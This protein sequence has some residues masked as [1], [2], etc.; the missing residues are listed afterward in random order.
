MDNTR[1]CSISQICE[2][3]NAPLKI[4][5]ASASLEISS[6]DHQKPDIISFE[7]TT[8]IGYQ[9]TI[10]IENIDQNEDD[11]AQDNLDN[12]EEMR[13]NLEDLEVTKEK[14]YLE[15][16]F[17][18]LHCVGL[19]SCK[20]FWK[21]FRW[22]IYAIHKVLSCTLNTLAVLGSLEMIKISSLYF[23]KKGDMYRFVTIGRQITACA[24]GL[25]SVAAA[26]TE[27]LFGCVILGNGWSLLECVVYQ[28]S[29][30][31]LSI[32]VWT[33]NTTEFWVK[34][35][36]QEEMYRNSTNITPTSIFIGVTST[37][38]VYLGSLSDFVVNDIMFLSGLTM[39]ELTKEFKLTLENGIATLDDVLIK[40]E[41]LQTVSTCIV[42]ALGGLLKIAHASML[43]ACASILMAL[44]QGNEYFAADILLGLQILKV[45]VTYYFAIQAAA[46]NKD[47]R[48]WVR[49]EI[50][51]NTATDYD[52][53]LKGL[54]L[55]DESLESPLGLGSETFFIDEVFVLKFVTMVGTFTLFLMDAKRKS[56][57]AEEAYGND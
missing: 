7:N 35:S 3:V 45:G 22:Q 11:N 53:K 38:I 18:F 52:T 10:E 8:S 54:A 34:Y 20:E 51:C 40:Y 46:V 29:D 19:L 17:G 50:I 1:R 42:E 31:S 2:L 4:T 55:H 27:V 57:L 5:V 37:A 12:R 21:D 9:S 16:Y 33:T 6:I 28:S 25:A 41:Q 36:L 32:F 44:V 24:V 48:R 47:F 26:V 14:S 15:H 13:I 39:Y 23:S 43:V 56:E 49:K 30:L